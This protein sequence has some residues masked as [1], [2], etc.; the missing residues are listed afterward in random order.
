MSMGIKVLFVVVAIMAVVLILLSI[1]SGGA[2][3]INNIFKS[4]AGEAGKTPTACQ[5]LKEG[6]CTLLRGCQWCNNQ[7]IPVTQ[8]CEK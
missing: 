5:Q 4:W 1:F 8:K 3:Q 7:C 2:G 6:D